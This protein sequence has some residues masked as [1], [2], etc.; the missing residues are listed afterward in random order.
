MQLRTISHGKIPTWR[1]RLLAAQHLTACSLW[2]CQIRRAMVLARSLPPSGRLM[3]QLLASSSSCPSLCQ[4][5]LD[6]SVHSSSSPRSVHSGRGNAW[7]ACLGKISR[8]QYLRHYPVKLIRADGSTIEIR[9][10]EPRAVSASLAQLHFTPLSLVY[11]EKSPVQRSYPNV[12]SVEGHLGG[13]FRLDT[14]VDVTV[15]LPILMV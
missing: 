2:Y 5:T 12:P 15:T 10:L 8:S 6:C 3:T 7:R 13:Y 4:G 14:P 11:G 9:F 1:F